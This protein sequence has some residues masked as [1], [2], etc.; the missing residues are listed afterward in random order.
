MALNY[1][2]AVPGWDLDE[3]K[4][5]MRDA[6]KLYNEYFDMEPPWDERES[7]LYHAICDD[8]DA[9]YEHLGMYMEL[10]YSLMPAK[11]RRL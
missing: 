1:Y 3:I 10:I 6:T 4:D 7:D 9:L 8:V 11:A 5:R 2:E